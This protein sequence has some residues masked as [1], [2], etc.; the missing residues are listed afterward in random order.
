MAS[1]S[2]LV[3]RVLR[4]RFSWIRLCGIAI[5]LVPGSQ[6]PAVTTYPLDAFISPHLR[7]YHRL[8]MRR[9]RPP[10][11]TATTAPRPATDSA[12]PN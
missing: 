9:P 2:A 3:P 5:P 10:I 8:G 11:P 6:D 7:R 12:P 1:N 4:T